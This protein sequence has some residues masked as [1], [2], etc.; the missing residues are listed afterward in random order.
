MKNKLKLIMFKNFWLVNNLFGGKYEK[1]IN[2]QRF[3]GTQRND[4]F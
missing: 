1:R 2:N 4:D 3:N